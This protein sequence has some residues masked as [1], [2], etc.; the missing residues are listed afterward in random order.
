MMKLEGQH[1][2]VDLETL[3][4]TSSSAIVSIGA[5]KF[6]ADGVLDT[7]YR[8]IDLQSCIRAGLKMDV[9]TV[10]W[11]MHQSD[12]ARAVFTQP[13]VGLR[14]ALQDFSV[15]YPKGGCLWGNGATFDNVILTNAYR[16]CDLEPPWPYWGD[17]CY[18]TVKALYK[19]I[20]ADKFDGVKHNALDDALHQARHLIKIA[21]V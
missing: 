12:E 3:G 7:F 15:W 1:V 11:W 5:A 18:R 14:V 6:T 10:E 19:H 2:M 9:N 20:E 21:S 16:A 4:N 13:G 17:R 8:R